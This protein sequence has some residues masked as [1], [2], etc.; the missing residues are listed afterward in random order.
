MLKDPTTLVE[1]SQVFQS[2]NSASDLPV[3]G[4]QVYGMGG[5]LWKGKCGYRGT[6]CLWKYDSL[7]HPP[8]L[9]A[10]KGGLVAGSLPQVPCSLPP[11]PPPEPE[12]VQSTDSVRNDAIM[13][14]IV[15]SKESRATQW[16][17]TLLKSPPPQIMNVT[18]VSGWQEEPKTLVCQT[19]KGVSCSA[20]ICAQVSTMRI[21]HS[22]YYS[23][24]NP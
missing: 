4:A 6:V 10:I 18:I 11:H 24:E 9:W 1:C 23:P 17:L 20:E 7:G 5:Q 14:H 22:N 15:S 12:S 2:R 13:S 3:H 8:A 16:P 21:I 19:Q